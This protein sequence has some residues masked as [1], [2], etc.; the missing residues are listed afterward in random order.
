MMMMMMMIDFICRS[1]AT[2]QI[3]YSRI[4][5]KIKVLYRRSEESYRE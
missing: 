2:N 3:V 5:M 1:E 4:S